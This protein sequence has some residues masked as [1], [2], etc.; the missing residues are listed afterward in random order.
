M[1][2]FKVR[3]L[4]KPTRIEPDGDEVATKSRPEARTPSTSTKTQPILTPKTKH[5]RNPKPSCPTTKL[6][7][8]IAT[9]S[10]LVG[11]LGP[12]GS[13]RTTLYNVVLFTGLKNMQK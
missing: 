12:H 3:F 5:P 11:Y 2:N 7:I 1:V 4:E 10:I 6:K 13:E 8:C 9:Q